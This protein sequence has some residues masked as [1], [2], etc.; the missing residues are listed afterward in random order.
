M[1]TANSSVSEIEIISRPAPSAWIALEDRKNNDKKNRVRWSSS[2]LASME[3]LQATFVRVFGE[4]NTVMN[5]N[6]KFFTFK[7]YKPSQC[8]SF[9]LNMLKVMIEELSSR[10]YEYG[11]ND[12]NQL[13]YHVYP[14]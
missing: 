2:Q 10:P 6:Q 14:K 4:G 5:I 9:A 3:K 7:V 12:R 1:M 13:L 11:F 8:K